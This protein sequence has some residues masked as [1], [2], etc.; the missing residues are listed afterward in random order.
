MT[1]LQWLCS[2]IALGFLTVGCG[3]SDTDPGTDLGCVDGERA[4]SVDDV[5]M[6]QDGQ[7]IYLKTCPPGTCMDGDCVSVG[8][9][10]TSPDLPLDT[11][12]EETSCTSDCAS[13]ECGDDGCGGTC[14]SCPEGVDCNDDGLCSCNQCTLDAVKCVAAASYQVCV[15]GDDGCATWGDPLACESGEC[16]QNAGNEAEICNACKPTCGDNQCGDDGCGGS[17]GECTG[18]KECSDGQCQCPDSACTIGEG[19]CTNDGN[20]VPCVDDGAGCGVSG[21]LVTC[22]SN[23]CKD[24]ACADCP[25]TCGD[26]VCG[27]DE[28]GNKCGAGT[29]PSGQSCDAAGQCECIVNE[30]AKDETQCKTAQS[31]FTCKVISGCGKWGPPESCPLYHECNDGADPL[32]E[33]VP[34]CTG[35]SCGGDKCGSECGTC[36]SDQTCNSGQCLCAVNECAAATCIDKKTYKSCVKTAENQCG[37]FSEVQSCGA[38]ESCKASADP[39]CQCDPA[40]ACALKSCGSDGCGGECAPGCE[41]NEKCQSGSCICKT[42]EC[43]FNGQKECVGSSAYRECTVV[44]GC[45]K[46]GSKINCSGGQAVCKGEGVCDCEPKCGGKECGPDGCGAFCGTG[47][48]SSNFC[49]SNNQCEC[50]LDQC[51]ANQKQCANG[52]SVEACEVK[53]GCGKWSGAQFCGSGMY[54]DKGTCEKYCGNGK[55]ESAQGEDCSSCSGDCKCGTYEECSGSGQCVC[56]NKCS[57]GDTDCYGSTKIKTCEKKSGCWVWGSAKTC[58]SGKKCSNDE[59]QC[60]NACSSGDSQCNSSGTKY[61]SCEKDGSCYEWGSYV[62]CKSDEECKSGECVDQCTAGICTSKPAYPNWTWNGSTTKIVVAQVKVSGCTATVKMKKG[63]GSAFT[64]SGTMKLLHDKSNTGSCCGSEYKSKGFSS[65]ATSVSIS[66]SI[67]SFLGSKSKDSLW[68][69]SE[70]TGGTCPN[71]SGCYSASSIQL[72]KSV[73]N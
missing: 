51:N 67:S 10:V 65:G 61:K 42:D 43:E 28:C 71:D 45:G 47:C 63:D 1:R 6:C 62:S 27:V 34:Q 70:T 26:K 22:P 60:D 21:D 17:C 14:G 54:C 8:E 68:V 69:F 18:S 15:A 66:V 64:S 38:N 58:S 73:C 2:S 36:D 41:S 20:L 35:K 11:G 37:S 48:G 44:N 19:S 39:V 49:N 30:C 29:C 33:C 32:C 5:L 12:T 16:N 72:M 50:V 9:D 13:K 7:M 3:N 57:S 40:I 25:N 53:D 31:F 23:Q 52:N 4:C 56:D 59:C 24:G 55:C 46:W